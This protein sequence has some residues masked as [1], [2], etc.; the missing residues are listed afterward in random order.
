MLP[1]SELLLYPHN[2]IIVE[3][4][5]LWDLHFKTQSTVWGKDIWAAPNCK[6]QSYPRHQTPQEQS[7]VKPETGPCNLIMNQNLT[8][9]KTQECF[10]IT[11]CLITSM[12]IPIMT[13]RMSVDHLTIVMDWKDGILIESGPRFWF[14]IVMTTCWYRKSHDGCKII[15]SAQ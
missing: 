1:S 2:S 9:L 12:R 7:V 6:K 5:H 8:F 15:L 14:N 4:D 3:K 10:D 13:I 11:S